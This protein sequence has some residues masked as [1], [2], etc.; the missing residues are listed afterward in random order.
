MLAFTNPLKPIEDLLTWALERLHADVGLSWGWS[1]VALTVMVRILLV[2]VVVRQIHSM[3]SLQRHAPE[4]KAIQQRYK[5]DRAKMN[6]ELMKFYKENSINPASSCL[7]TLFQIPI[8][9]SLYFVLRDFEREVFPKYESSDL[10]WLGLIPNITDSITAH[11]SGYLLLVIYVV[12][13]VSSSFFM[14]TT[15][16]KTQRIMFMALPVV[17]VPFIINPPGGTVFPVGL[18]LYWMTT[19]LWVVGQGL[20]T[21]RMIPRA[22]VAPPKKSSRTPP[23]AAAANGAKPKAASG[24]ATA[25]AAGKGAGPRKVKRKKKGGS[26]R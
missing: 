24:S 19:N 20:M 5:G 16:D 14:M 7:P 6:E 1:I 17:F 10:G 23:K 22:P 25:A 4:M 11:W 21:R 13:Q 3:Q 18:L 15:A 26:R 8:F 2:P 9:F 12:S